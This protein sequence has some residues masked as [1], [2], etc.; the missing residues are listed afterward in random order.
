MKPIKFTPKQINDIIYM[1]KVGMPLDDIKKLYN[2]SRNTIKRLLIKN[3]ITKSRN[4][5][6]AEGTE[7]ICTKCGIIKPKSEFFKRSLNKNK[8][9]SECKSCLKSHKLTMEKIIIHNKT[10]SK[11]KIIKPVSEFHKCSASKDMYK[12]RCKKCTSTQN[13]IIISEKLCGV[14]NEIKP[15][16][17]FSINYN[18]IDKYQSTCKKCKKQTYNKKYRE[19]NKNK[20]KEYQ[21][22]YI[23]K[24]KDKIKIYLNKNIHKRRIYNRNKY[25]TDINHQISHKLRIRIKKSLKRNSKSASTFELLGCNI[26]FLKEHLQQTALNNGYL[27]FDI[28]NYSG[29]EY[30]IDHIKPCDFFD[31]SKPEEQEMCFHYSNLQILTA[32]ENLIK[33]NN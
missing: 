9:H 14:C 17:E 18:S 6:I 20:L 4:E 13:Y 1:Y 24:N 30:H 23:E 27:D 31:L 15:I 7:K 22:E 29:K 2:C 3:K 12:P 21:K 11:C 26:E 28:N 5:Y 33:S 8:I 16:S 25:N 32:K 19:K 10:C